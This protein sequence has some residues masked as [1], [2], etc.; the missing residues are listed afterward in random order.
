VSDDDLERDV[1]DLFALVVHDLRNPVATIS[2]NVSFVREVDSG[3]DPDVKEALEDVEVALND[4]MRGIEQIGWIGRWMAG[5]A[6]IEAATGEVRASVQQAL[7]RLGREVTVDLPDAPLQ[8]KG[9][10]TPLARIIEI[11]LVNAAVHA[12]GPVTVRGRRVGAE[13]WVETEDSGRALAGDL[14]EAAMTL[15]GQQQLKGR[16]DGRYSRV[17]GLFAIRAL[18]EGIGARFEAAGTDGAAIFRVRLAPAD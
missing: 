16:A 18:A 4:L 5:E 14:R 7:G 11:L 6:A 15:P 8:V 3:D 13:V 2:A 17:A 9:G 1:G 12:P 10:G